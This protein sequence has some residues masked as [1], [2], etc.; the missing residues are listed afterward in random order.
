MAGVAS[1]ETPAISRAQEGSDRTLQ[2]V[3]TMSRV[4]SRTLVAILA[5]LLA[6]PGLSLPPPTVQAAGS[7]SLTSI[8]VPY[9]EDFNTL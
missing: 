6:T 1:T 7:I 2:E 8:G 9:A 5:A 4:T 3:W